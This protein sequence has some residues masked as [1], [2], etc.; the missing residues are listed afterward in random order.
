MNER[1][2]QLIGF[3]RIAEEEQDPE[4]QALHFRH[5]Q[6]WDV[7]EHHRDCL[8]TALGDALSEAFRL[9]EELVVH[10]AV[11]T[12]RSRH[13][14]VVEEWKRL[15]ILLEQQVGRDHPE[16]LVFDLNR[17]LEKGDAAA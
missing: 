17:L 4:I 1:I 12:E 15:T 8:I 3:G 9:S 13:A 16:Q 7:Y 2:S 10:Q 5:M 11:H 6:D 14:S